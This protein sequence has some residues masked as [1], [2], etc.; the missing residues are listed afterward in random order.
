MGRSVCLQKGCRK[1]KSNCYRLSSSARPC[2]HASRC[3]L[4]NTASHPA[5]YCWV[6]T[7]SISILHRCPVHFPVAQQ[8][9]SSHL[10]VFSKY[11]PALL[12]VLVQVLSA[13]SHR[14]G[15]ISQVCVNFPKWSCS[16]YSS[17][18]TKGKPVFLFEVVIVT[19]HFHRFKLRSKRMLKA[20]HFCL[21]GKTSMLDSHTC[22]SPGD[23]LCQIK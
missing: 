2:F 18:K 9:L 13:D 23:A 12:T 17:S 22:Q 10:A 14:P 19:N 21:S 3:H 8:L 11:S 15:T 4:F 5:T 7:S 16:V 6:T 20:C 1:H